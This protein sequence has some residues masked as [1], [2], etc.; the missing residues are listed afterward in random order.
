MEEEKEEEKERR[1]KRRWKRRRTRTQTTRTTTSKFDH[2]IKGSVRSHF[3]KQHDW[4][5]ML[6]GVG[7]RLY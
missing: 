3:N 6:I 7:C 4:M 5:P 1:W 2:H